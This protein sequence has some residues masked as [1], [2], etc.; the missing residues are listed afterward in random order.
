MARRKRPGAEL[1]GNVLA[2]SGGVDLG[3]ADLDDVHAIRPW[4]LPGRRASFSMSAP[5]LA[6]DDA[7]PR[8]VK[9]TR[10]RLAGRSM[11]ILA[12]P[13]CDSACAA[14]CGC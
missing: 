14:P 1:L 7:G 3:L 10:A 12:T 6:D 4:L 13:A 5:L 11:T 8:G 2:I 9:V